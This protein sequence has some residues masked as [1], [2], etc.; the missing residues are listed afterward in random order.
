MTRSSRITR[1]TAGV[2]ALA[3][4]LAAC[5]ADPP[6]SPA[7]D[8]AATPSLSRTARTSCRLLLIDVWE[9]AAVDWGPS[10]AI[11]RVKWRAM[12]DCPGGPLHGRVATITQTAA[13][14]GTGDGA[15]RGPTQ[16]DVVIGPDVHDRFEGRAEVRCAPSLTKECT[17]MLEV[18]AVGPRGSKLGLVDMLIVPGPTGATAS[19]APRVVSIVDYIDED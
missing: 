12:G 7:S 16:L 2:A 1:M 13:L 3:A 18:R 15:L 11:L 10:G 17:G 14:L 19:Y 9:H 8:A 6:A 5:S 4:L